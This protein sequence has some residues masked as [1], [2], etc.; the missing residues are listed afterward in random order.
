MDDKIDYDSPALP[1][2][3]P[4]DDPAWSED[5]EQQRAEREHEEQMHEGDGD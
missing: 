3:D 5:R 1:R 2:L 4:M